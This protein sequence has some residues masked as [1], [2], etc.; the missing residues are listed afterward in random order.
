MVKM[1]GKYALMEMLRAEGVT[2]FFGYPGTIEAAIMDALQDYQ[3][4]QYY[5]VL[6][7]SSDSP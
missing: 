6:Q 1:Q 3:D 7:E 5:L 2:L 4:I